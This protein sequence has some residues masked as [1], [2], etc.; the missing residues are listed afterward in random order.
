MPTVFNINTDNNNI[1]QVQRFTIEGTEYIL[2]TYFNSRKFD[3]DDL[4][5]GSWY[6]ELRDNNNNTILSGVKLVPYQDVFKYPPFRKIF[7]GSLILF[8]T[9]GVLDD[10]VTVDNY[11]SGKRYQLM[12]FTEEEIQNL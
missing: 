5:A 4:G 8:D 1:D 11:G 3:N 7:S 12:Y 6:I 2:K 10:Q 9:K